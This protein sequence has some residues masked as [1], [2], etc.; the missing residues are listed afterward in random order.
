MREKAFNAGKALWQ[1]ANTNVGS[2]LIGGTFGYL[3][4]KGSRE[5]EL[6][7][8]KR[9]IEENNQKIAEQQVRLSESDAENKKLLTSKTE[10]GF[11]MVSCERQRDHWKYAH[12]NSV[13]LFRH[14]YSDESE[15]KKPESSTSPSS[16]RR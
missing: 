15:S 11:R 12:Q 7:E 3:L 4:T 5:E 14:Y 8:A 9:K 16:T 2:V 6:N 13:C 1:Y 10:L